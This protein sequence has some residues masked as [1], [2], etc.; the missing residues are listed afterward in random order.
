VLRERCFDQHADALAV[1]AAAQIAANEARIASAVLRGCALEACAAREVHPAQFKKCARRLPGCRVLLQGATR[2]ALSSAQS[3]LQGGAQG[4]RTGRRGAQ[5]QCMTHPDC[6]AARWSD[7]EQH[8]CS[9]QTHTCRVKHRCTTSQRA[10]ALR[11]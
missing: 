4:C 2:A 3:G 9:T 8:A 10:L 6:R 7:A 5:Q 11:R 1:D